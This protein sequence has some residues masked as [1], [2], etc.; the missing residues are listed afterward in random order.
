LDGCPAILEPDP[1][2]RGL[3]NPLVDPYHQLVLLTLH[4]LPTAAPQTQYQLPLFL[5]KIDFPGFA[6]Q[7][8]HNELAMRNRRIK[9]ANRVNMKIEESRGSSGSAEEGR[10]SG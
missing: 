3:L 4:L 5:V 8:H 10:G 1:E 9:E 6:R 7:S 2:V